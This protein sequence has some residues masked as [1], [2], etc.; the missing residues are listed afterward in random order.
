MG[1]RDEAWSERDGAWGERDGAWVGGMTH[2]VEGMKHGREGWS[3]EWEGWRVGEGQLRAG[4]VSR[5]CHRRRPHAGFTQKG[6]TSVI[7]LSQPCGSCG[8]TR[9]GKPPGTAQPVGV[10]QP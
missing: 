10:W 1:G 2:G 6:E 5:L 8:S 7:Q 9:Q 4:K 3:M